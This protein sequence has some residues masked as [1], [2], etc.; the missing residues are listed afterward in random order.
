MSKHVIVIGAGI[1]GASIAYQLAKL[2]ARVTVLDEREPGGV[3]T[4]A[5][6]AW[7]NASW[8]NPEF[9]F[10]LRR[11]SMAEWRGLAAEVAELKVTWCGGLCWDITG[12]TRDDFLREH[13]RWGYG[14]SLVTRKEIRKLEPNLMAPPAEAIHVAE[15]GMVE[16]V[17]AAQALLAAARALGSEVFAPT[18]VKWLDVESGR[19]RG[20]M[21][22]EGHIRADEVV[23]AAGAG[24]DELLA[25]AGFKLPLDL[26][27][28]LLVHTHPAPRLLNG[29]V[30]APELHLRQTP[31]GELVAGSDFG[32][33]DP[34]VDP[35][36]TA[37]NLFRKV[38]EALKGGQGPGVCLVLGRLPSD[39]ARW[40]AGDRAGAAGRGPL[41]GGHAF[42]YHQC[43]GGRAVCRS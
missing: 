39:A 36:E 1:I 34:G 32:G 24:S 22:E 31:T 2:G 17:E 14:M 23:V 43:G 4:G 8:G 38:Q 25:S 5:S 11:R 13:S 40:P 35:R 29:L 41:C 26:P 18:R 30:L 21:L 3:A 10:R 42:G 9:Y 12:E 6:F 20:V 16:P 27:P 15:E 33:I 37:E 28:G 19:I 7:I